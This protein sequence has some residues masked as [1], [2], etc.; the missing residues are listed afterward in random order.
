MIAA[1]LVF[2]IGVGLIVFSQVGFFLFNYDCVTDQNCQETFDNMEK[3]LFPFIIVAGA[4]ILSFGIALKLYKKNVPVAQGPVDVNRQ[5]LHAIIPGLDTKAVKQID[6]FKPVTIIGFSIVIGVG[7]GGYGI[8]YLLG[9][10][11]LATAIITVAITA[12]IY[13]L[14]ILYLVRKW[15]KEWNKKFA[16]SEL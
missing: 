13:S 4:L 8:F 11:N 9:Q 1:N 16:S 12:T 7:F 10:F 14:S 15:S 3:M 5:T 6:K 2:L